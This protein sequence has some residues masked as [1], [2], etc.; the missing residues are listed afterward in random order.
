M[1]N[2]KNKISGIRNLWFDSSVARHYS[3]DLFILGLNVL[4]CKIKAK[5]W[6]DNFPLPLQ[7]LSYPPSPYVRH[8][9]L[10]S[11]AISAGPPCPAF[12]G[13]MGWTGRSSKARKREQSFYLSLLSICLSIRPLISNGHIPLCYL[14]L[15]LSHCLPILCYG[16]LSTLVPTFSLCLFRTRGDNCTLS[17]VPGCFLIAYWFPLT[18]TTTVE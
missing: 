15:Q 5:H 7:I 4:I 10:T 3:N 17:L 12:V 13:P 14:C 11:G 6:L 9:M 18:L 16:S 8:R 1:E 2:L